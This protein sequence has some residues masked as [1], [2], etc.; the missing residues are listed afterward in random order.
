MFRYEKSRGESSKNH[1]TDSEDIERQPK[2]LV[3]DPSP[4][5]VIEKDI[6][7]DLDLNDV[8]SPEDEDQTDKK[9][10]IITLKTVQTP[11]V[12]APLQKSNESC[13][14]VRPGPLVCHAHA[15]IRACKHVRTC[16][17]QCT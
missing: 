7:I 11:S 9:P 4:F 2:F 10:Q 14:Y 3:E 12:F 15:Y 13:V 1:V 6:I 17:L 16:P 8:V 5:N